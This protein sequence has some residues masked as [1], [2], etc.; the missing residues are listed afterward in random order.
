LVV[1]LNNSKTFTTSHT[2]VSETDLHQEF[3]MKV[4]E[5][6]D[7]ETLT[8]STTDSARGGFPMAVT[9]SY[10]GEVGHVLDCASSFSTSLNVTISYDYT[11]TQ[12]CAEKP[13]VAQTSPAALTE[14]TFKAAPGKTTVGSV[15]VRV[16]MVPPTKFETT[17]RRWYDRQ[18]PGSEKDPN[19]QKGWYVR[20]ETVKGSIEGGLRATTQS[21]DYYA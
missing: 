18:L 3:E 10:P 16:A 2:H 14:M 1:D 17:A 20:D 21:H 12:T 11:S 4:L 5:R 9:C 15:T 7:T 13:T 8:V 6:P 19:D